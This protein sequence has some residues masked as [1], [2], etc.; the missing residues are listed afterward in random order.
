GGGE[1]IRSGTGGVAAKVRFC[2]LGDSRHV[3]HRECASSCG[4]ALPGCLGRVQRWSHV[5]EDASAGGVGGHGTRD[6]PAGRDL[7]QQHLAQTGISCLLVKNEGYFF[8][9]SVKTNSSLSWTWRK[10]KPTPLSFP[11]DF[12]FLATRSMHRYVC[13]VC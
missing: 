1:H 5:G 13:D 7:H 12:L 9:C 6:A 3:P 8:F 4:R 2:G 10:L 11:V